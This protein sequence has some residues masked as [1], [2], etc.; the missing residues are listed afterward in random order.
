MLGEQQLVTNSWI[1]SVP[2]THDKDT[3]KGVSRYL[4]YDQVFHTTQHILQVVRPINFIFL[5]R[6]KKK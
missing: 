6:L 4:K 2:S 1:T 3:A 5:L